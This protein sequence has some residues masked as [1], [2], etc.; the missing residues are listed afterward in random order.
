MFAIKIIFNIFKVL[1]GGERERE[2]EEG[3]GEG[4]GRRRKWGGRE[5]R[6]EREVLCLGLCLECSVPQSLHSSFLL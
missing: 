2:E 6:E 5:K 4:R 1:G 3:G